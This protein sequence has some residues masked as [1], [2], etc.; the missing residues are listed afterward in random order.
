MP[1][2]Y[3]PREIKDLPAVRFNRLSDLER[4]LSERREREI[5]NNNYAG[6]MRALRWEEKIRAELMV[7]APFDVTPYSSFN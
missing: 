4:R 2:R 5:E 6:A 3:I 1:K 7:S